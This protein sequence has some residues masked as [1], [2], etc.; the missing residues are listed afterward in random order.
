MAVRAEVKVAVMV[1]AAAE[2][3]AAAVAETNC[4]SPETR[5]SDFGGVGLATRD[6][7]GEARMVAGLQAWRAVP[8]S[9]ATNLKR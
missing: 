5:G 9:K 6:P 8:N 4:L 2:V 1:A 3:V 7:R